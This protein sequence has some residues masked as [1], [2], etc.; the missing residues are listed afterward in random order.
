[1]NS[2]A[3]PPRLESPWAAKVDRERPLPEYPRPSL[4]RDEWLSL[5]GPWDYAIRPEGAGPG[6]FDGPILVP[7]PVESPLSGAERPLGPAEVL[8][9]RRSF[10]VPGSWRG[11]RVLV[12]FGAAD[13]EARVSL[14]GQRLGSHRGGY[15][16]F[17]FDLTERL[18]WGEE[19][20]VVELRDPT[21]AGTQCRGKQSLRP[22]GILYTAASGLWGTVWLEPVPEARI[23]GVSAAVPRGAAARDGRLEVSVALCAIGAAGGRLRARLDE[24]GRAVAEA[25]VEL[26]PE[27][28]SASLEL[29]L[30][31]PRL[32]SPASPF[33]YG[34]SLELESG[35]GP[36][37]R[38]ASYAAF[39][40]VGLGEG[41]RGEARIL[42][43]GEAL[44]HNAVLDQGYWPEGVYTAPTDEALASDIERAKELGF[45]AIRKHAKVESERWY[46]HCDRLGVLVW[47]DV[48]AGGR[49]MSLLYSVVLGFA[50]ARL[51]DDRGLGRFGRSDPASREDFAREAEEIYEYLKGF[52]CV[53]A[54]VPFNEGW[55]QFESARFAR[56]F[57][58]RD[59]SRLVDAASGWYDAGGGHFASRHDYRRRPRAPRGGRG[60]RAAVLSEY[61]G[62]TLRVAGHSTEDRR[63]FG[64]AGAADAEDLAAQYEA[65]AARLAALAREG[66]AAAVYTQISDVEIERNGLLTYDRR[67]VKADA[68]R[69][70]AANLALIEA[71]S[72]PTARGHA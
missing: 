57:A 65:L 52:P 66:L 32:W 56:E 30:R 42:L 64:Y 39:R 72:R 9:Y 38:V 71:G 7:F 11:R 47:Q 63:Q 14:N 27:A 26:G 8:W 70:R 67:L 51:R 12:H 60:A 18:S 61:G 62:L 48:P 45:N 15:V 58:A 53:V 10:R 41:P 6:S 50:G 36:A 29:S 5:N 19:E 28:G 59:P 31:E 54:W 21:D 35:P 43:N 68:G 13:W 33:L 34:L 25:A 46:W 24:G 40:T 22:R 37:D 4:V 2:E 16:P 1:M 49:N 44:F 17:S 23:A 20:L 55:G 69:I 3:K